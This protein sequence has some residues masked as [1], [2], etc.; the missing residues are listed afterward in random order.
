VQIGSES[1]EAYNRTLRRLLWADFIDEQ[2]RIARE[3]KYRASL[4][5]EP[6]Q[7]C[8]SIVGSLAAVRQ[9]GAGHGG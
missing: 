3:K 8:Q 9:K 6:Y 1:F 5:E 4:V 7:G 2:L